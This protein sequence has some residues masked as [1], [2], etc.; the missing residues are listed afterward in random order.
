MKSL[1]RLIFIM[2]LLLTVN[3]SDSDEEV[4]DCIVEDFLQQN[5]VCTLENDESSLIGLL[6]DFLCE[7]DEDCQSANC[8]E[9]GFTING[10]AGL[11]S[12][13]N[14]E[15]LN[16]SPDLEDVTINAEIPSE[17]QPFLGECRPFFEE[18]CFEEQFLS[19]LGICV[20]IPAGCFLGDEFDPECPTP[21]LAASCSLQGLDFVP[22]AYGCNFNDGE[23]FLGL[24]IAA[25]NCEVINC[26]NINCTTLILPFGELELVEIPIEL[27]IT[28]PNPSDSLFD[29][30]A[31]I[32]GEAGF[33]GSCGGILF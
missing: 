30:D 29:A 9:G 18:T 13:I 8:L 31:V 17:N 21:D 10:N 32:D 5:N 11:I 16:A 23:E 27:R 7:I 6:S 33:T 20:D 22:F 28:D 24:T 12:P 26:F 2:V 14:F 19:N 3:C 4:R 25:D 15:I 1:F